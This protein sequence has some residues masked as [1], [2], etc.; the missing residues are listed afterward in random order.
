MSQGIRYRFCGFVDEL[1]VQMLL[2][3]HC[4][5]QALSICLRVVGEPR[6]R[7][8]SQPT[9]RRAGESGD[10]G[11]IG[12][13][14][15]VLRLVPAPRSGNSRNTRSVDRNSSFT[16]VLSEVESQ[17]ALDGVGTSD[18]FGMAQG[19][20]RVVIAGAPVVLHAEPRELV[21]LRMSLVSL[22]PVDQLHEVV[23]L[24]I[25]DGAQHGE[26]RAVLQFVGQPVEYIRQGV[27]YLLAVL[28]LVRAGAGPA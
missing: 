12:I 13:I 5:R 24:V 8:C 28:E 26:L 11:Y 2:A 21:V 10:G 1:A 9:D 14:H 18:D 4:L 25:G 16:P 3:S 23:D 7:K 19:S 15:D 6:R 22:G 17:D 20:H 27:A